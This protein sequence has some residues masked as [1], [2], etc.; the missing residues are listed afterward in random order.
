MTGVDKPYAVLI[1]IKWT[2]GSNVPKRGME[3]SSERLMTCDYGS[4]P[5]CKLSQWETAGMLLG[6]NP[7][8]SNECKA[9]STIKTWGMA[10]IIVIAL[11]TRII[12]CGTS[13]NG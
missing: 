7:N 1:D 4:N 9:D 11:K 2:L 6:S 5:S 13:F 12:R 10:W 8:L 3:R